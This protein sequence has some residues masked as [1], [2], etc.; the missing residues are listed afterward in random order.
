[1]SL[2]WRRGGAAPEEMLALAADRGALLAWG[3]TTAGLPVLA[4]DQC[5]LIGDGAGARELPW[6][7]IDRAS[8]EPPTLVVQFRDPVTRAPQ[9]LRLTLD[10]HG[11]LPPI[12][13]QRVTRSVVTSRR[14]ELPSGAGAVL[15][16]R[17]DPAGDITWTV[18]FDAGVDAADPMLQAQAREALADFRRS[19][20]V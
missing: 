6:H 13:R 17:R 8:W 14:V 3:R 12:I 15:A 7:W 16:A 4:T 5:L 10:E 20:G 2:R 19:L 9:S 18:V 1:M 11:E